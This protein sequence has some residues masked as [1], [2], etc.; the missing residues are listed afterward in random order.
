[1]GRKAEADEAFRKARQL[2]LDGLSVNS[3]NAALYVELADH[4]AALGDAAGARIALNDALRLSPDDAHTLFRLAVFYE[5]RLKARDDALKWLTK[6]V[7]RGQTWREI[8]RAP[9]LRK[10][11]ADPRFQ[12]LRNSPSR[13]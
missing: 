11:R 5:T 8:D 12:Q 9:E 7:E 1:L 2:V 4:N 3:K 10:L 13:G 6:A